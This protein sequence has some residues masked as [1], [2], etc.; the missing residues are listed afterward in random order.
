RLDLN[1]I[2]IDYATARYS[3]LPRYDIQARIGARAAWVYFDSRVATDGVQERASSY[4][5]GAGPHAP[6]D[7]ERRF[8][9]GPEL[10]LYARAEGAVLIGE[11]RQRFRE[12]FLDAAGNVN[13]GVFDVRKT[14]AVEVLNL[15]L[16]LSFHPCGPAMD[17][18][19]FTAGYQFERWWSVGRLGDSR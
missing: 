2:D 16:G 17:C 7:L 5:S 11:M 6:L 8:A 19:R 18:V 9:K 15:Q 1:Q 13:E 3:P 12:D 10:G 4:F 14:Q